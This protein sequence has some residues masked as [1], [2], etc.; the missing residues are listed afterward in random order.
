MAEI[1]LFAEKF[2]AQV[3]VRSSSSSSKRLDVEIQY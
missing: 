1:Y 3:K 2:P